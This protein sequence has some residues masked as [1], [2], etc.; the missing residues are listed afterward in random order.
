MRLIAELKSIDT[1]PPTSCK[2]GNATVVSETSDIK[3]ISPLMIKRD[4]NSIDLRSELPR[5]LNEPPMYV[6][7]GRKKLDNV[8]VDA[9]S[10][11]N[12]LA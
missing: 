11:P 3:E 6:S 1:A 2:E 12:I 8:H 9:S 5:I 10:P 4:G 7:C